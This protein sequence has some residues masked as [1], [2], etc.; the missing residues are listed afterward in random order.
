MTF[1]NAVSGQTLTGWSLLACRI[2]HDPII[3]HGLLPVVCRTQFIGIAV[4]DGGMC[5]S[6]CDPMQ[7]PQNITDLLVHIDDLG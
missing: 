1:F 5:F 7:V 4:N 2:L 6:S 3:L